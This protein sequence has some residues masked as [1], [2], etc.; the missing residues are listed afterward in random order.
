MTFLHH[1]EGDAR[2]VIGLQFDTG[3]PD[4]SELMLQDLYKLAFTHS[5]PVDDDPVWFEAS[6]RLV[7]HHQMLLY[8]VGQVSYDLA[9]VTL[10]SNI[11]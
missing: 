7:E 11:C 1:N 4:G 8:H 3:L 10:D 5:I 6:C 9:S 2:L